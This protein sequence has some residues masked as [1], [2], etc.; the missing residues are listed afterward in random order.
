MD[1]SVSGLGSL[2]LDRLPDHCPVCLVG[3]HAIDTKQA[4]PLDRGVEMVFLCPRL[5]CGHFFIARYTSSYTTGGDLLYSLSELH[6]LTLEVSDQSEV[7]TVVSPDFVAIYG[8]AEAAELRQLRLVC[9]PGY[10]KSLEFLIKDYVIAKHPKEAEAIKKLNLAKCINDYVSSDRIKQ[11][12]ARAVWLGNDE[13][14]YLRRWEEKD[15][16]DL[17]R[18]ISLTVHWIEMEEMTAEVITDMPAGK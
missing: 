11:V 15:L 3:I 4:V 9:G 1:Y 6:P 7:I 2:Y 14:H 13:T 18:V 17:K 16:Q 10:R 8:E 5:A 12:A